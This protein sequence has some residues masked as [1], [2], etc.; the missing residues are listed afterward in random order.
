MNR[1]VLYSRKLFLLHS[2]HS[3]ELLRIVFS[4]FLEMDLQIFFPADHRKT[5]SVLKITLGKP[6]VSFQ[7]PLQVL[8]VYSK[9]DWHYR[10]QF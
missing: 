10:F 4:F 9:K 2:S 6:E 5:T 7:V 3:L 8:K 1:F